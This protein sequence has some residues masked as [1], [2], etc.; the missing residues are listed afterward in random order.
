MR[1]PI[2]P[3]VIE[4]DAAMRETL[5]EGKFISI[6]DILVNEDGIL[7]TDG[8]GM[9][10]S[11]DRR[12]LTL[13]GA[14]FIGEIVFRESALDGYFRCVSDATCQYVSEAQ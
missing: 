9:L 5:P 7:V 6:Y 11:D 13:S 2:D 4:L 10:L 8:A 1:N 12:H 3:N 14:R